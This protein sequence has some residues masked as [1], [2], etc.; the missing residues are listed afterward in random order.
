MPANKAAGSSLAPPGSTGR[1]GDFPFQ[2]SAARPGSAEPTTG[3]ETFP[4]RSSAKALHGFVPTG[5]S[6]RGTQWA[7]GPSRHSR[8]ETLVPEPVRATGK[9]PVG[10]AFQII[11]PFFA[12]IKQNRPFM[13]WIRA[14]WSFDGTWSTK[15][16]D[17]LYLPAA[18][19]SSYRIR[20]P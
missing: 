11:E 9:D 2:P 5:S 7:R 14:G 19:S 1:T 20:G 8:T 15:V 13:F 17:K 3:A 16:R 12:T 10:R 6:I 4:P 18:P